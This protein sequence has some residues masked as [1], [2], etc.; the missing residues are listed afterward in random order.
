VSTSSADSFVRV[1]SAAVNLDPFSEGI[2]RLASTSARA[3]RPQ[4]QHLMALRAR[5]AHHGGRHDAPTMTVF[6]R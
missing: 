4:F 2:I 5:L 3:A 6:W 1:A